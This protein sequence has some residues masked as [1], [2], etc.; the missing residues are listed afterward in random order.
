MP[1][2]SI[3]SFSPQDVLN[4]KIAAENAIG[5]QNLTQQATEQRTK[6]EALQSALEQALQPYKIQQMK[7]ESDLAPIRLKQ[8][9]A[10][11]DLQQQE[12]PYRLQALKNAN[13]PNYAAKLL[14]QQE[15]IRQKYERRTPF[16]VGN[17]E[18]GAP[19]TGTIGPNG[20]FQPIDLSNILH[21]QGLEQPLMQ[22]N[23]TVV[24]PKQPAEN[25]SSEDELGQSTQDLSG[26]SLPNPNLTKAQN[27]LT[28]RILATMA[29]SPSSLLLPGQGLTP[30]AMNMLATRYNLTGDAPN[31][32]NSKALGFQKLQM[33][34]KA[35]EQ[36][37][38]QGVTPEQ[39][40]VSQ[41]DIKAAQS[42]LK[43]LEKQKGV[44]FSYAD[45]A[46]KA[47]DYANEL[48][49]KTAR[50]GLPVF[51][52]WLNA[53]RVATGDP[54]VSQFNT[55]VNTAV[56]EYAKATSPGGVPTDAQRAHAYEILSSALTPEQFEKNVEALHQEVLF[57]RQGI[58][59][60]LQQYRDTIKGVA[61][62]ND[63]GT[64]IKVGRF[65]V[66]PH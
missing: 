42:G 58:E 2:N 29:P 43:N 54:S 56:N 32:G 65:T 3:F 36:M 24:P 35:A 11:I 64:S 47:I 33:F 28:Q 9:Q 4:Q 61:P 14:E 30:E 41:S 59:G 8:L 57:R 40:I 7:A 15:Q 38:D 27:P 50:S 22:E 37:K 5:L 25:L 31:V 39:Q 16:S 18:G 45:T 66:T 1:T 13:D 23:D 20:D 53:G 34:N 26:A 55:A 46:D 10:Q 21:P 12:A 17:P 49:K 48:S 6:S 51:N 63:L 62:S 60:Q 52:T 44:I 19:L